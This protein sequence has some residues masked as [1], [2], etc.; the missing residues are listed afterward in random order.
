MVLIQ[1]NEGDQNTKD[2]SSIKLRSVTEFG[3]SFGTFRDGVFGKLSWEKELDGR[4]DRSSGESSSSRNSNESSGFRAES[5]EGIVH[6]GVHDAHSSSGD[7]NFWVDLF[8]DFI[9]IKAP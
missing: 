7:T 2:E 1:Y 4:L 9:D 3:N 5:V 8:K 6:E